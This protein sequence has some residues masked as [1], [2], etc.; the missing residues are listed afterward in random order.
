MDSLPI[1]DY[2]LLSDCRSAALV[3]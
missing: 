2:A 3:S 1:G